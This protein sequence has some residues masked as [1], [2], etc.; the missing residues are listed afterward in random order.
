MK[1][2]FEKHRRMVK[3]AYP[4]WL[5]VSVTGVLVY[6]MLYQ[7][8]LP[9]EASA[10]SNAE[11]GTPVSVEQ[12]LP[13]AELS[14][15]SLIIEPEIFEYEAE[16]GETEFTATFTVENPG[17]T[18]VKLTRLDSSCTCLSVEADNRELAP[19]ARTEI[20]AV[21]DIS[22]LSGESEKSVY[23]DTD[24][25]DSRE[26]RLGVRVTI[27]SIISIEPL[28][29]KWGRGENREPRKIVFRVLRDEPIRVTEAKSSREAVTLELKTV[30]EGR[31]YHIILT[32]NS[33]EEPLLGFVRITTD[34]E[35]EQYQRHMAYYAVQN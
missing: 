32:P 9:T 8:F 30:E 25:P 6:F 11:A 26:L 15:P 31:E 17:S 14:E 5:Y 3:W 4:I 21:F 1:G 16:A 27:P 2:N 33:T 28:T 29:V 7:W 10:A 22:K 35:L 12:T 20:S 19:G 18:P 24:I 23:I 13:D 34:C